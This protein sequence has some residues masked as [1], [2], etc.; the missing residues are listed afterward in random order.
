M[1]SLIFLM[2]AGFFMLEGGQ[3]KSKNVG[4]SMMKMVGHI[5]VGTFIFFLVG[6]AIKQYGFPLYKMPNGWKLPWS[7]ALDGPSGVTFFVSLVFALVSCAIPSGAFAERMRFRAYLLFALLYIG[8]VYPIFA[9][10]LWNGFLAK[11]GVQDYAGSLGVHAV[12]GIIGL[13]GAKMLGSRRKEEISGFHSV[14]LMGMG[15]L[16][17]MFCWFG[18][19]LGSVPSYK[20]MAVDLPWVAMTTILAISGGTVGAMFSTWKNGKP[21]SVVTPNGGLA[22]AVAVCSGAHLVPT[23]F[24]FA[25]GVVASGAIPMISRFVKKREES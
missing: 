7:F 3:V 19:N 5:G 13:V 17:L 24:A 15:A 22:G 1:G 2:Q 9:F 8:I 23:L 4:N 6:F 11:L 25:M 20:N 16:L 14:P 10:V 18:F 12:G 21:D